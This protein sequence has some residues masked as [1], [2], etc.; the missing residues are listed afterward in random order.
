MWIHQHHLSTGAVK[1][2]S[3]RKNIGIHRFRRDLSKNADEMAQHA[4]EYALAVDVVFCHCY[5]VLILVVFSYKLSSV[6][7]QNFF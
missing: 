3:S 7:F 4:W 1:R 5:T 6:D 2:I